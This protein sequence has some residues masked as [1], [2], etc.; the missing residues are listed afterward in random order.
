MPICV[1]IFS[2]LTPEILNINHFAAFPVI[3]K[4]HAHLLLNWNTAL[5]TKG[6]SLGQR[7]FYL[8]KRTHHTWPVCDYRKSPGINGLTSDYFSVSYVRFVDK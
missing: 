6:I 8:K 4:L 1:N 5:K 2:V 3:L 7:Y